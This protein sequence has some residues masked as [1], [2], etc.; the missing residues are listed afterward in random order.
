MVSGSIW[1]YQVQVLCF[2]LELLQRATC[3][4]LLLP[5]KAL[6]LIII[7]ILH[8]FYFGSDWLMV[9]NLESLFL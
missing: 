3:E 7:L 8:L 2:Y 1:F 5:V 9:S 6:N 4:L